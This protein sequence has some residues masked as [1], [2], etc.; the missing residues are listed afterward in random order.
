MSETTFIKGKESSLESTIAKMYAK[1]EAVGIEIDAVSVLNPVPFVY[2]QHIRN[3]ACD[4]MFTNGKGA[5]AKACLA[6]ALGEY[7]E[8]L[9]CN[10]FFA[11]YYL[12]SH[13]ATDTFVHYPNEKWFPF[14]S[15]SETMPKGI[16]DDNL[17]AF[18]D[19]EKALYPSQICDT[20]SGSGERGI[21]TLPFV[22]QRDDEVIYFPV[23]I[24]GNL[25]V[26]NGMSAGN[27]ATEARIQ[28]LC[29]IYERYV[30]NKIIAEGICLPLIPTAILERFGDIQTSIAKLESYGYTLR[31]CDASL[32][33][34]YPVISVTL[35]HPK[36]GSVFASFGAHPCFEVAL[37]RTVT[38]L[39]QGR[40]LSMLD[41][42]HAPSFNLEEVADPQNLETHFINATG[43]LSYEFFK[44]SSDYDFVDW[45]D[46]GSI[47]AQ[48]EALVTLAS[49]EG[50]DIYIADYEHLGV[51]ACR[52]LVP[53]MSEI[54]PVE[55]LLWSNNNEGAYFREAFLSL[56][57]LDNEEIE[58][59][60][61][62]LEEGEY[63]DMLKIAE[64]IG[65]IPDPDTVW[66][67]L[68]LGELKAMFYLALGD[69]AQ[70][71]EWVTW[72]NHIA[73][74]DEERSKL[75]QCLHAL[76]I[77]KI[78]A[79]DPSEYIPSLIQM[80]SQECVTLCEDILSSKI[81]F[82]GLHS[83]GLSLKG[84]N[85]HQSLLESYA[86]VHEAKKRG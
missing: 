50:K 43:L 18:Y 86:L 71:K 30:K 64:F 11:D 65:V 77:I 6:S 36:D 59:I 14:D 38:E 27:T 79:K 69:Y 42:F 61:E 57:H 9:S 2:S 74:F 48:W 16:L 31:I 62:A 78:E 29:E 39:L 52:M 73:V 12:G 25:Y 60:L 10:Y 15:Q 75:Y 34:K 66:Q 28:A 41:D 58:A 24:I 76:L 45:N 46:E 26:S 55:D 83:S 49:A 85:K 81:K 3:K 32:G 23:N 7:F 33:G 72:C 22:R 70:A 35:I 53:S 20:N 5:S 84:F 37:E 8:R 67:T 47:D 68:Q 17:W 80:Y 82:Q 40:T 13:F 63:S 56:H 4:L 54:Y 51:Y 44:Q 1:L 19:P 21:C